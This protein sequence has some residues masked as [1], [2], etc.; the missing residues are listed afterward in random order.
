[1]SKATKRVVGMPDTIVEAGPMELGQGPVA[2]SSGWAYVVRP[3]MWPVVTTPSSRGGV[4][5]ASLAP[6]VHV[7]AV[8]QPGV[9]RIFFLGGRTTTGQP[10]AC[11]LTV[12]SIGPAGAPVQTVDLPGEGW[13]A[14]R[15]ADPLPGPLTRLQYDTL[16]D[17]H[18]IRLFLA[19]VWPGGSGSGGISEGGA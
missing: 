9:D 6:T 13:Y 2:V 15:R 16:P 8:A 11:T 1:M 3:P 19:S 10:V 5:V 12:E 4:R 17:T 14:E 7:V 18:P